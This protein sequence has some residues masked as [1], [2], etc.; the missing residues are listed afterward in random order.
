VRPEIETLARSV[1]GDSG[2]SVGESPI[3]PSDPLDSLPDYEVT[4]VID[5]DHEISSDTV[6]RY[7]KK[8]LIRT[9]VAK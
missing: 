7:L 2:D 8:L 6:R 1:P 5:V 4:K 3:Q 9:P